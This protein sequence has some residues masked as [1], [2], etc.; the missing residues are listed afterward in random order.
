[1]RRALRLAIG[2]LLLGTATLAGVELLAAGL[3]RLGPRDE[4]AA[5]LRDLR[6]AAPQELRA[7]PR[8]DAHAA[9]DAGEVLHPYLG[10]A[11]E[12]PLRSETLSFEQLGFPGGGRFA[13]AP[14]PGAVVVGVFGGS[15]ALGFAHD[16]G[17][18]AVVTALRDLP[19]FAGRQ[20]VVAVAAQ[21]GYKQPQSLL[22]LAYLLSLGAHFDLVLLLDGFNEV[23]LPIAENE[24][25]GVFPFYPRLW[26]WRVADLDVATDLR[27]S[28]GAIAVAKDQRAAWAARLADTPLRHSSVATLLWLVLD[29]RLDADLRARRV[30]LA[31]QRSEQ[32]LE[33]SAVGP[34]WRTRDDAAL[35]ADL[36]ATW[37]RGAAAMQ[38]LCASRGIPFFHFLQPNQYA[39]GGK[40]MDAAER[41]AA[42]AE[43][44]YV[45]P[46]RQGYPLL[47]EAGARARAQGLPF[48]D[49]TQAFAGVTEPLYVDTCCHV[50]AR[51]HA[52]L[53]RAMAESIREELGAA[54]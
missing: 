6:E 45:A 20:P 41:A 40:P 50:S 14:V 5:R 23:V 38:A 19:A 44:P 48:T 34:P 11:T 9:I 53:A 36:V 3:L 15:M 31:A 1:M 29:R 12:P 18:E 21:A 42:L 16:G 10:Y 46:A 30:R 37:S 8:R 7:E 24:P 25:L 22:A 13:R 27:E 2:T 54:R 47:R 28:I 35:R 51:G 43:G 52:L 49:L 39:D 32:S 4:V 33:W 17:P 26:A